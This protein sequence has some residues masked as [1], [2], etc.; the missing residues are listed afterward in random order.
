MAEAAATKENGRALKDVIRKCEETI[1]KLETNVAFAERQELCYTK[2]EKK[3]I[4]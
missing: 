4:N 2:L 3:G 1:Y